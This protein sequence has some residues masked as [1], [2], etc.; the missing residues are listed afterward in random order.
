MIVPVSVEALSTSTRNYIY[1][2]QFIF[3]N[4]NKITHY[5][6]YVWLI[7]PACG[8]NTSS[9][10]YMG[11]LSALQKK[12]HQ[13]INEGKLQKAATIDEQRRQAVIKY[14]PDILA[15]LTP[16]STKPSN[17]YI[18]YI[19]Q[20]PDA[21]YLQ[22]V[23]QLIHVVDVNNPLHVQ[24]LEHIMFDPFESA[25]DHLLAMNWRDKHI[26]SMCLTLKKKLPHDS[27]YQQVMSAIL[28][29]SKFQSIIV[30]ALNGDLRIPNRLNR[31]G[32]EPQF[33][34]WGA[35]EP[36][37]IAAIKELR[38]AWDTA[39]ATLLGMK[40]AQDIA[41][42]NQSWSK[43]AKKAKIVMEMLPPGSEEAQ[44]RIGKFF[45]DNAFS[46]YFHLS[47]ITNSDHSNYHKIMKKLLELHK[48][49]DQLLSQLES[50]GHF[51]AA[52]CAPTS[53]LNE[54][55]LLLLNKQLRQDRSK[56]AAAVT[57]KE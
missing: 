49:D 21:D 8:D 45:Y 53:Y 29:G 17:N 14:I 5:L 34:Q 18:L 50:F 55:A 12:H 38:Q 15:D 57:E 52:I 11:H 31:A 54:E 7:L 22:A 42:V 4:M 48:T 20:L 16:A 56:G 27:P 40:G 47:P 46:Q 23:A 3:V 10:G 6:F 32:Y 37:Q 44:A 25:R 24:F 19:R 30:N 51:Q 41:E 33:H 28:S 2:R 35:P 13:Y 26:R 1:Q 43:A 9:T 39:C 36:E